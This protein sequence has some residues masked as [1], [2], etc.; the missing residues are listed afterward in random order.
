MR[1]A[2]MSEQACL[3]FLFDKVKKCLVTKLR[4]NA[5]MDS[6]CERM[7]S[8]QVQMA[9]ISEEV[10]MKAGNGKSYRLVV[11]RGEPSERPELDMPQCLDRGLANGI[12]EKMQKSQEDDEFEENEIDGPV[13]EEMEQLR[14]EQACM[15]AEE[16]EVVGNTSD[17]E[18]ISAVVSKSTGAGYRRVKTFNH[19]PEYQKLETLGLTLIPSHVPGVFLSCHKTSR[20]WQG[21]YPGPSE[22]LSYSFGGTTKRTLSILRQG[23]WH[24][25]YICLQ[26][27]F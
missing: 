1:Q 27:A 18:E 23:F 9:N 15:E 20:S 16:L 22:Q 2:F 11:L 17:E 10:T 4:A 12:L 5:R 8:L 25:I 6:I 13:M 24:Y 19:L 14:E 3:D 26:E 21:F 7:F